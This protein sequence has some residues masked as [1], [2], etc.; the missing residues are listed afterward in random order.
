[1][2]GSIIPEPL[3][4][5]VIVARDPR[6]GRGQRLGVRVRR[7]DPFGA[8]ERVGDEIL[9]HADDAR[10][11]RLDRQRTPMTPVELTRTRDA[12]VPTSF[13]AAAAI[14]RADST[15]SGPVA[16]LL[17]LLFATIARSTPPRIVSRPSMTGA[18]GNWF[19]VKTAAAVASTSLTKSARSFAAGLRPQFRLAHRNPRG[20]TAVA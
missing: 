7:H 17:Y 12:S 11:D 15:P 3:A 6:H 16:T 13:A 2:F 14:R 1:M 9:R 20:K 18:P 4:T 5:Q 10:L 19:R 8:D